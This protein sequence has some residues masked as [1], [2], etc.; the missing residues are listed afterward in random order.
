MKINSILFILMILA[1]Y[2]CSEKPSG[3]LPFIGHHEVVDGDTIFH[4]I[5]KFDLVNQDSQSVTNRSLENSI[6][7]SDFFFTHCPSI[8]PKVKKQM[9]R[10]YDKY[11]DED[12]LKLVSHTLDPKRDD[13][14]VLNTYAKNLGVK[15]DKWLFLTGDKDQIYDLNDDYFIAV[16]E[17]DRAPG[18]IDH[19]GKIVLVD[20]EGHVRAFAEGT[21]PEDVTDFFQDIDRLIKEYEEK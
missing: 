1:I 11:E 16:V 9:L 15:S 19:S 17:D 7:V 4:K 6:Y 13:V 5:P 2:S 14:Q 21:D 8:C 18:G 20:K 12:L 3:P 10:I